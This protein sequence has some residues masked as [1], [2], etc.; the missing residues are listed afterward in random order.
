MSIFNETLPDFV[1]SELE[2]RQ[3]NVDGNRNTSLSTIMS[4]TAWVRMTSGV[5]TLNA[6]GEPTSDLAKSNII[7]SILGGNKSTS[8]FTLMGYNN[9]NTYNQNNRHGI[10]PLPGIT[11]LSCQSY[12]PNGSLRKVTVRFSCHDI[13][14]LDIME[15]LYM[16][17]GY[18]VCIEWGWSHMLGDNKVMTGYPNFGDDFLKL[19]DKKGT[20]LLNLYS[21]AYNEI[22]SSKG[23]FDICIGKVQNYHYTARPDGGF[24]CETTIVTYGEI[25]DSLKINY[26]PS[27]S[28]ISEKGI[29][30]IS[31]SPTTNKYSEGI[32]PGILKELYDYASKGKYNEV[33]TV[34]GIATE[35]EI[36]L[37]KLKLPNDLT[38]P[39]NSKNTLSPENKDMAI[40]IQ[41]AGLFTLLNKYV[42]ISNDK[43]EITKLRWYD[44]NK[45]YFKCVAHPLQFSTNPQV[46]IINPQ[47]WINGANKPPA[48]IPQTST[49]PNVPKKITDLLEALK[50]ENKKSNNL[51]LDLVEEKLKTTTSLQSAVDA[52]FND[53]FNSINNIQYNGNKTIYSFQNTDFTYTSEE[54]NGAINYASFLQLGANSA[55]TLVESADLVYDGYD[56]YRKI[57]TITN[58]SIKKDV[59][60]FGIFYNKKEI[61]D[62]FNNIGKLYP[63]PD[64]INTKFLPQNIQ[65]LDQTLTQSGV[66]QLTPFFTDTTYTSGYIPNIYINL[67]YVY[68][69]VKPTTTED[70]DRTGKNEIVFNQ[71]LRNILDEIQNSIGSINDFQ[72]YGDYTDNIIKIIDRNYIK[73]EVTEDG[74]FKF[75][76]DNTSSLAESYSIKSQIFPEQATQI[77]ISTQAN[78]GVLGY[79][80]KG[81]VD[82]NFGIIDRISPQKDSGAAINDPSD[83]KTKN[84]YVIAKSISQ[85]AWFASKCYSVSKDNKPNTDKPTSDP[86]PSLHNNILRDLIATWDSYNT[87]SD[88]TY[89]SPIPVIISLRI[90]GIAGIKIGNLFDVTGGNGTRILP[91][92]FEGKNVLG[93]TNK[94][95]GKKM[96]FLVRNLSHEVSNNYWSTNIEGYPFTLPNIKTPTK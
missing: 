1:K 61:I 56:R 72:I 84:N 35:D 77:A 67:D 64:T 54:A 62:I 30:N 36:K 76:I 74:I 5:N 46:C 26:I 17:P 57:R 53:I 7:A 9:K 2:N 79:N 60:P 6:K 18:P 90:P 73:P 43:G 25:L 86:N 44:D 34:D 66:G 10:R 48:E 85:L 59:Y 29:L 95:L 82:Y 37:F 11:G 4:S 83:N 39:E 96:V 41:L 14:Q 23:N 27:N 47:G 15:L 93:T 92:S 40:Y 69:L 42:I 28:T 63:I 81:L 78:Q 70:D 22:T 32:I 89:A 16:R 68:T 65:S 21:K 13:N 12:S 50:N 94:T 58:S 75:E 52:V 80:N 91:A 31:S 87:S 33:I 49:N 38:N 24:D 8:D 20:S 88:R 3:I 55:E 51:F 45:T 71:F 19:D